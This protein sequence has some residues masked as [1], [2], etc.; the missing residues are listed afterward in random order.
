VSRSAISRGEVVSAMQTAEPR[1]GNDLRI[2]CRSRCYV[3]SCRSLFAQAEMC[4][5]IVVI[6]DVFGHE[7]FQVAFIQDDYVVE[8]VAAAVADEAFG[9]AVLP[10]T[11]EGSANRFN[12]EHFCSLYDLS[13]ESGIAIVNQIARCGVVREGFAQLLNH[14]PSPRL[15]PRAKCLN[16]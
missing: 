6:A 13:T 12:A 11:L 3:P 7:P 10:G 4:P 15:D 2:R 9:D 5:V 1:Y 16:A 8:Q 14:C